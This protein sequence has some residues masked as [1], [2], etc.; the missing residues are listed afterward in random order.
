[1]FLLHTLKDIDHKWL[2]DYHILVLDGPDVGDVI[3]L[4]HLK[5]FILCLVINEI[6]EIL[7]DFFLKG[8]YQEARDCILMFA[9]CMR[10]GLLPNLLDCGH[11]PRYNCRDAVWWFIKAI[12]EYI[13]FTKQF[14]I[15]KQIVKMKFLSDDKVDHDHRISKGEETYMALHKIIQHI[16]QSHATGIKFREWNSGVKIDK[17]MSYQ[18][19]NIELMLDVH[20]GF[21]MGGNLHNCLTWMDKMGS[22]EKANNKGVPATPRDGAPIELTALLKCGLDYLVKWKENGYFNY[23]GVQ[24][25]NGG[26]LLYKDWVITCNYHND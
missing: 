7:I 17:H 1:M 5:V 4:L 2:L 13:D 10:H 19:F 20:T 18:G 15:L 25:V 22:S 11:N 16:F 12:G 26:T 23:E 6:F 9:S 21:I 14:D 3:L 24:N 8:L